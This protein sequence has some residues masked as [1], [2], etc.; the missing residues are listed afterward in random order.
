MRRA[1]SNVIYVVPREPS[2]DD[3]SDAA[4]ACASALRSGALAQETT[5][6]ARAMTRVEKAHGV[7]GAPDAA[8]EARGSRRSPAPYGPTDGMVMGSC[9]VIGAWASNARAAARCM[10]GAR[11]YAN[12]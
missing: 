6:D 2:T 7:M 3:V 11:P 4:H 1:A 10:S 9:P 5:L 8:L 12:R